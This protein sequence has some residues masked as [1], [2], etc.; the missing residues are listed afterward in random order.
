M[1]ALLILLGLAV[2]IGVWLM[3]VYNGLGRLRHRADVSSL[4]TSVW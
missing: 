4:R 1:I 2:A 3:G